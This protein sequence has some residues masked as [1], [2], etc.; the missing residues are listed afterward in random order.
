MLE[1]PEGFKPNLERGADHESPPPVVDRC[2]IELVLPASSPRLPRVRSIAPDKWNS[3]TLFSR[4]RQSQDQEAIRG[5]A[6]SSHIDP[7][8]ASF[9]ILLFRR[10]VCEV[11][12]L[13]DDKDVLFAIGRDTER[14]AHWIGLT[15]ALRKKTSA[16]AAQMS[17]LNSRRK[18]SEPW[19]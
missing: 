7:I 18:A 12:C 9:A 16:N 15:L 8:L 10:A 14:T 5:G 4:L 3:H 1:G 17:R 6:S 2:R 11:F 13:T 19:D